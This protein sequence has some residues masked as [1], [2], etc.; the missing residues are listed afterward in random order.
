[1]YIFIKKV[2]KYKTKHRTTFFDKGACYNADVKKDRQKIYNIKIL[3]KSFI[4]KTIINCLFLEYNV[5]CTL[6]LLFI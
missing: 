2:K 3:K 5:S 1:M 4:I 6:F